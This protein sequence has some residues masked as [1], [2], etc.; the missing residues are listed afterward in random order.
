M[1]TPI[2]TPVTTPISQIGANTTASPTRSDQ[3]DKDTFLKLLVAQL[4]Y[5]D[6][7]NP[8]DSTAFLAQ[9][10]QFTQVERLNELKT[11][12]SDQLVAQMML[13]ASGM[14]GK[15]ITFAGP[16]GKDVSG[17]VT[18]AHFNGSAPTL[19]VGDKDVPL[20]AVKEV[21]AAAAG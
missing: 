1:T 12:S 10:A 4:K 6:P 17:V 5:Q 19:R 14:V 11:V 18:S 8:A 3:L 13:S 20:P 16:D 2:H 7:S 9:T 21:K 15:T